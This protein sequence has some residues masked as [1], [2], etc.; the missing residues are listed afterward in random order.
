MGGATFAP[1]QG[2][3]GGAVRLDTV[4]NSFVT[5]GNVLSMTG[6]D[7]SIQAWIKLNAGDTNFYQVAGKQQGGIVSGY[8]LFTS[9]I[10]AGAKS[11]RPASMAPTDLRLTMPT[12]RLRSMMVHGTNWWVCTTLAAAMTFMLMACWRARRQAL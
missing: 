8:G 5:M 1:G 12:R 3:N 11:A 2:S 10:W 9:P 7:F 4:T 6:G